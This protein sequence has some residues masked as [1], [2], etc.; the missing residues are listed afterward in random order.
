MQRYFLRKQTVL[1]RKENR[2]EKV[3][4]NISNPA[5]MS[6]RL[7]RTTHLNGAISER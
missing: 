5:T 3:F 2:R 7:V 6:V 1:V 4:G